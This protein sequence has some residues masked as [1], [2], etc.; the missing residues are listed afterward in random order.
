MMVTFHSKAWN[1]VTMFG[2]VAAQMLK[3]MGHSGT[4]PSALLAADVPR[5]IER[6]QAALNANP[7]ASVP[8][9]AKQGK[10]DDDEPPPVHLR[11]RAFPL[12]ELL[13]AA[14]RQNADVTW[15]EGAPSV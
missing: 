12:L 6:L 14:A 8:P 2:D 7:A 3:M 1:S 5:A 15:E 4:V 11:Q 13:S 10:G 9:Q